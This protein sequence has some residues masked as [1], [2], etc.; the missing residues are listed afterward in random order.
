MGGMVPV[1]SVGQLPLLDRVAL[2]LKEVAYGW[3][4]SWRCLVSFEAKVTS[5]TRNVSY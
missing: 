3:V 2:P 4:Y 1:P 5:A